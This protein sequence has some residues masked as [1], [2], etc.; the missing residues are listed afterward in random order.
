MLGFDPGPITIGK[1][2]F[3]SRIR[4]QL[5]GRPGVSFAQRFDL[6][7]LGVKEGMEAAAGNQYIRI[8]FSQ[9]RVC[10]QDFPGA[11]DST[12]SGS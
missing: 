3:F 8:L 12:G 2:Q 5:H 6:A 10:Y 11:L 4:M 7:V 1:A 9:F